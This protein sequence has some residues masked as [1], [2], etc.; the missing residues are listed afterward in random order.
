[1]YGMVE[2]DRSGIVAQ[3]LGKTALRTNK[4]IDEALGGVLFIDEAYSL[5][6]S[7][8]SS[9]D[10]FALEALATLIKRM[11]G[12]RD[13]L[14]VILAG[15]PDDMDRPLDMNPGLRSRIGLTV[16]FQDYIDEEL[17]DILVGTFTRNDYV[18]SP[19][20]LDRVHER[21]Q[22]TRR[23]RTFGNTRIMRNVFEAAIRVRGARLAP[24]VHP[25]R[26]FPHRRRVTS[27]EDA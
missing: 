2:T 6:P 15:Y 5:A 20:G 22:V 11:E 10:R 27:D 19:A 24:T 21:L 1:M 23:T 8:G 25:P 17:V 3:C 16:D 26:R 9:G 4:V 14:I 13:D 12:D 7:V 18:A